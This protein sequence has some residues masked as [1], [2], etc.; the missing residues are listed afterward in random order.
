MARENLTT[1]KMKTVYINNGVIELRLTSRLSRV[2]ICDNNGNHIS[3]PSSDSINFDSHYIEWMITNNELLE[4]VKQKF[5]REDVIE[6]INELRRIDISL[7]NSEFYSRAAQKQN[8]NRIIGNFLIYKYEE[9]YYS[10]E[11]RI[12]EGLQVKITFKMGDYALAAHMFVLIGLDNSDIKLSNHKGNIGIANSLG[13]GAKIFW[14][15]SNQ[16]ISE[17]A[18]ALACSSEDHKNDLINLLE[19]VS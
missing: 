7:K 1:N 2:R 4:I 17:I 5:K 13:A 11:K 12:N 16:I 10:F 3:K 8:I 15:P 6:L 19:N 18:K 9:V 14:T